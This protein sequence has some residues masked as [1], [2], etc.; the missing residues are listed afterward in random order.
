[1]IDTILFSILTSLIIT[2]ISYLEVSSSEP[3]N[4]DMSRFFK[5]FFIAFLVN[6]LGIFIYKNMSCKSIYS[7]PVEVGLPDM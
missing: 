7:Q 4:D 1:M 2:L 6:L 5:L 3:E